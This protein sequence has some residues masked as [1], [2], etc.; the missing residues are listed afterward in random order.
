[1][2][3]SVCSYSIDAN[4][5]QQ[6]VGVF[7]LFL[8]GAYTYFLPLTSQE[9]DCKNMVD[10]A[11]NKFGGLHVAFNNAGMFMATPFAE[12]TEE[13]TSAIFDTNLKSLVF[14]FKYQV[15]RRYKH[16]VVL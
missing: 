6:S 13:M 11:V 8:L 14:C 2:A 16:E 4:H 7:E 12:A 9:A 5:R 3:P 10:A 1:M 15:T